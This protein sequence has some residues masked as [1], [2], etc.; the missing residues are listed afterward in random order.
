M[1]FL[2]VAESQGFEVAEFNASDK[3]NKAAVQDGLMYTMSSCVVFHFSLMVILCMVCQ[4]W[5]LVSLVWA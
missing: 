3:R 4:R 1:F 5:V 2:L